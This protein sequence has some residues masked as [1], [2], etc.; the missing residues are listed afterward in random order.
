LAFPSTAQA[1][2]AT[3]VSIESIGAQVGLGDTDLRDVVIRVIQWA[4]GFISLLAVSYVIYGG[5]L[6]LTSAGN[7]QRVEKAKQVILQALIGIVIILLAW[8][9]VLFVARRVADVTNGNGNTNNTNGSCLPG[10]PGCDTPTSGNSFNITTIATCAASTDYATN[11]PRSSNVAVFFSDKLDTDVAKLAVDQSK[12]LTAVKCETADCATTASPKP[13]DIQSFALNRA[14]STQS[15][16]KTEWVAKANSNAI[17]LQHQSFSNTPT[18]PGYRLFEPNETYRIQLPKQGATNALIDTTLLQRPLQQCKLPGEDDFSSSCQEDATTN[19]LRWSFTTGNDVAGPP[20]NVTSTIPSSAYRTS[21]GTNPDRTMDRDAAVGITFST[22]VDPSSFSEDNFIVTKYV[23]PP[24]AQGD[25]Q[26]GTLAGSPVPSSQFTFTFRGDGKGAWLKLKDGN[27]FEP[28]TWY[29]VKVSGVRNLCGSAMNPDPYTWVFETNDVVPGVA[30]VYP[31]NEFS[32]ACPATKVMIVFNTSMWRGAGN[33]NCDVGDGSYVISGSLRAGTTVSGRNLRVVDQFNPDNPNASCRT[34]E[35]DPTTTLLTPGETYSAAVRT[36]KVIDSNGTKLEY[37]DGTNG[38]PWHFTVAAADACVQPPLITRISPT[39][40]QEGQ[41]VTVQ[42][43]YFEKPTETTSDGKP[44][45]GDALTLSTRNQL[46]DPDVVWTDRSIVTSVDAGTVGASGALARDRAYTYSVTVNYPAPIGPLTDTSTGSFYLQDGNGSAGPCLRALSKSSGPAGTTLSAT[47]KNFDTYSATASRIAYGLHPQGLE[48]TGTW[49]ET[50]IS[51]LKVRTGTALGTSGV[52][53]VDRSGLMSN[54]IPFT[55]T[56]TP[57]ATAGA[58]RVVDSAQCNLTSDPVQIPSPNPRPSTANACLTTQPEVRF[59][60]PMDPATLRDTNNVYLEDC[61]TTCSRVAGTTILVRGDNQSLQ[62]QTSRLLPSRK[63]TVR[64]TTGVKSATDIALPADYSWSF[65]TQTGTA[66]CPVA[67]VVI[68]EPSKTFT[69]LPIV[70]PLTS[71]ARTSSC[72]IVAQGN[73]AYTW[74]VQAG[75]VVAVTPTNTQNTI[76]RNVATPSEATDSIS[77]QAD[78][79][80]SNAVKITYDPTSCQTNADCSVNAL[81]EQCSG[82]ICQNNRCTPVVNSTQPN[83]GAPGTWTTIRGCWFGS[84]VDNTSQ[85][86]YG[87]DTATPKNGIAPNT[88]QCGAPSTTWRNE[89]IIREV[90]T[91]AVT[92]KVKVIRGDQANAQSASDYTVNATQYPGLCKAAPTSA[93]PGSLLTLSGIRFGAEDRPRQPQSATD[94]TAQDA[95][96]LTPIGTGTAQALTTYASWNDTTIGTQ[97]SSNAPIGHATLTVKKGGVS[98]NT[99]PYR[100]TSTEGSGVCAQACSSDADVCPNTSTGLKQGCSLVTYCCDVRPVVTA[101]Q[102]TQ[103]AQNICRNTLATIT[104]SR[105]LSTENIDPQHVITTQNG[106]ILSNAQVSLRNVSGTGKVTIA[107]GLLAANATMSITVAPQSLRGANGVLVDTTGLPYSFRTSAN[108]CT[109]SRVTIDPVTYTATASG[110]QNGYLAQAFSENGEPIAS[111]PGSYSWDWSWLSGSTS[112]VGVT[113][114][115]SVGTFGVASA[116]AVAPGKTTITVKAKVTTNTLNPQIKPEKTARGQYNADFCAAPWSFIDA[117][118]NCDATAGGCQ[119]YHFQLRYCRTNGTSTLPDF[120]YPGT[121]PGT[122]IGS[123]EGRNTT[124]G[125]LKSMFFKES[126]SSTDVLGLLIYDNPEFLSPQDWFAARFPGQAVSSSSYI[127]GYPAV[128]TGTTTYIGVTDITGT[129]ARGLMFVFDYNSNQAEG[130]TKTIYQRILASAQ[131]NTNLGDENDRL[132]LQ[133]DTQRRQDLVAVKRSAEAYKTTNGSYPTLS[134]GTYL[135]GLSTS[136]WPSW[137]ATLGETLSRSLPTDPYNTFAKRCSNNASQTCVSDS[138]CSSG[139][140]CSTAVCTSPYDSATCWA[141]STK[142]FSCPTGSSV[143]LSRATNGEFK[144]Y[145]TMEYIGAG[146]FA[147]MSS[148]TNVCAGTGATCACFNYA[149]P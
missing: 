139:G 103:G 84:Y 133:R 49:T 112:V 122:G 37:G 32:L 124:L 38:R 47:G 65:T 67:G 40:G 90:P 87:A 54:E 117:D 110:E 14:T 144:V 3:A 4:L 27:L 35:F 5:Y 113:S 89:W 109:L 93:T 33:T 68:H 130:E 83:N 7:E 123:I 138:Q 50:A 74:N 143:Y 80:R 76:A 52:A 10:A 1:Q 99:L 82:S 97:L 64:L 15:D 72:Q 78:T 9:I 125:R 34:Y 53:V 134:A 36:D 19:T 114:I 59:T 56:A 71:S 137:Q 79:K 61:T 29:Q 51:A 85:V 70:Y 135:P 63:Y 141:E 48:L 101:V 118:T 77:V 115:G 126:G 58:P 86:V 92:G 148:A 18:D 98:S 96:L 149:L 88:A 140:K 12:N 94:L 45:T 20:M 41:C 46:T 91:G 23:N 43:N 21:N 104:F 111:I 132:A 129:V 8:A 17:T 60:V 66:D 116:Q 107:P 39:Q 131:F 120:T 25:W 69:T 28:F 31:A 24:S 57:A 105:P 119:D 16:P 30:K 147:N 2:T 44:E 128:Q 102:P 22:A 73:V 100:V 75:S 136:K 26:N 11:V 145:A 106:T 146:T 81:G 62:I 42:G 95:A 108:M 13:V 6:W 127:A 121:Q 55:T 142:S